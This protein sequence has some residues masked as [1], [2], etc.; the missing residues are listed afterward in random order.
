MCSAEAFASTRVRWPSRPFRFLAP[1]MRKADEINYAAARVNAC[2]I[3]GLRSKGSVDV[4][5]ANI[6]PIAL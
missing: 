2:G 1:P 5:E 3:A 6:A 4:V